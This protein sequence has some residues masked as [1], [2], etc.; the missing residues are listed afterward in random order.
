LISIYGISDIDTFGYNLEGEK[1][2]RTVRYTQL[3]KVISIEKSELSP[4]ITS[5]LLKGTRYTTGSSNGQLEFGGEIGLI[6]ENRAGRHVL[7]GHFLFPWGR[8]SENL[9][10][11]AALLAA[12]ELDIHYSY[13]FVRDEFA[14]PSGFSVGYCPAFSIVSTDEFEDISAWRNEVRRW[15]CSEGHLRFR[16][17]FNINLFDR[18]IANIRVGR[19]ISLVDWICQ[20]PD[21]GR[22]S[23]LGGERYLW[24][25]TDEEIEVVRPRLQ[26]AGLCV[27]KARH[28]YRD[29]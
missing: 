18:R 15:T 8:H 13:V 14:F 22:L 10:R 7:Y 19:D 21:R 6:S 26:Q 29:V 25:L 2:T 28:H 1:K 12:E 3:K 23:R 9:S 17:V 4:V 20:S 27:A 5:L 11:E 24:C 16:D